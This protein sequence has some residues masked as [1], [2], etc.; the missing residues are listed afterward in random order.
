MNRRLLSVFATAA[1]ALSACATDRTS[2]DVS[3]S[4]REGASY[5]PGLSGERPDHYYYDR[6]ARYYTYR[7]GRYYYDPN[8]RYYWREGRYY[9]RTYD[10]ARATVYSTQPGRDNSTPNSQDS[11]SP[12]R[13][14]DSTF[15]PGSRD[16]SPN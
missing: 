9:E 10:P 7:D 2:Y 8:G 1:L 13:R 12:A 4:P 16:S 5:R 6:D 15:P 3:D 11:A 14:Y